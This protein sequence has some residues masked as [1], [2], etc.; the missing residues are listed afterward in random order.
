[1]SQF[2]N[3]KE[4][5]TGVIWTNIIHLTPDSQ[6]VNV[7]FKVFKRGERRQ[8]TSTSTGRKY[9]IATFEVA[10]STAKINLILWND[11]IDT[12]EKDANY[13]L[14][15]GHITLYD[16]CMSL[17]KGRGG[18]IERSDTMIELIKDDVDMSR[19]FMWKPKRQSSRPTTTRTL[20]G[21]SGREV[22]RY[23]SRKSF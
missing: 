19:P 10:D 16:E 14:L 1:M 2:K 11:D 3:S 20:H 4:K 7:R 8:V 18:V 9:E 13:C 21:T 23:S 5:E 22:R 17:S 12:L 15:N 6:S